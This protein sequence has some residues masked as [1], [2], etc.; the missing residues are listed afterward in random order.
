MLVWLQRW[1][2]AVGRLADPGGQRIGVT[3]GVGDGW[4]PCWR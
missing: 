4:P 3:L 2:V 1:E